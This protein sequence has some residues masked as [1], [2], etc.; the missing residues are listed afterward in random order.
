[1]ACCSCIELCQ[2]SAEEFLQILRERVLHEV[3]YARGLERIVTHKF[4]A[5]PSS[6][7]APAIAAMKQCCEVRKASSLMLAASITKDTIEPLKDL[8]KSQAL[9]SKRT[10]FETT[11]IDKQM[12]RLMNE[13][14]QAYARFQA[15][16][17][18]TDQH[19]YLLEQGLSS[20]Q[21]SRLI[22]TLVQSKKEMDD[23]ERQYH[24]SVKR[25]NDFKA[26]TEATLVSST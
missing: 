26:E 10:S 3:F 12:Q 22:S 11:R 20:E 13:H 5:P 8:L 6:T 1:M 24:H 4:D 14:A 18:T 9:S 7:L 21:R 17:K 23:S 19:T 25:F 15:A 16:C 2:C